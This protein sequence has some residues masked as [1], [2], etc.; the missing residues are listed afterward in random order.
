MCGFCWKQESSCHDVNLT[1]SLV[2]T[3]RIDCAKIV[4]III[5][6]GKNIVTDRIIIKPSTL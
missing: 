5:K 4:L 6:K 2:L 1:E 3:P